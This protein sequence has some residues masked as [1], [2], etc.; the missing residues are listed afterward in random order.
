MSRA[1]LEKDMRRD[2]DKAADQ[3]SGL[4]AQQEIN[5]QYVMQAEELARLVYSSYIAGRSTFLEVQTANT[6]ALEAKIQSLRT[7][8]QV[9]MQLA[10]L[11]NLSG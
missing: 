6:R 3:L 2:R 4:I 1:Q 10:V 9:L 8:I 11:E 7:D 5:R